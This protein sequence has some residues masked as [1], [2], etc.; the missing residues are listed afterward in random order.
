MTTPDERHSQRIS[1]PFEARWERIREPF[2]L[3]MTPHRLSSDALFNL[4]V[5]AIGLAT[6]LQQKTT[7]TPFF[8]GLNDPV[9]RR[10]PRRCHGSLN[11][12]MGAAAPSF[13]SMIFIRHAPKERLWRQLSTL[14]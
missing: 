8:L 13:L 4:G 7:K 3:A 12:K 6:W 14:F 2:T 11:T 5:T 9:K 10:L 1:S